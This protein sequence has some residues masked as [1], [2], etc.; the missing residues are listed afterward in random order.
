MCPETMELSAYFD[1]ELTPSPR[2]RIQEHLSFCPACRA[3]LDQ[4]ARQRRLLESVDQPPSRDADEPARF[5]AYAANSRMARVRRTRRISVPVPAAAVAALLIIAGA[6]M[7][8][9][10]FSSRRFPDVLLVSQP[11]AVPAVVSLTVPPGAVDDMLALLEGK[12]GF[13]GELIHTLP[14]ELPVARFGEPAIVRGAALEE[15]P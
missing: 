1:D 10:H 3:V 12:Q 9:I 15:N 8:L 5:W 13:D 11:P 4:F 6:V 2:A 14:A 7:H